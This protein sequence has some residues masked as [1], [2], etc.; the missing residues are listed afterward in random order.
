MP[1]DGAARPDPKPENETGLKL[2]AGVEC[3]PLNG[4]R[5]RIRN[6]EERAQRRA[7]CIRSAAGG[8]GQEGGRYLPGDGCLATG[9]LQLEE[10]LRRSGCK[11]VARTSAA[12][13]REPEAEDTGGGSDTGQAYSAGGAVK[14]SLTPAARRELVES[15][16][17]QYQMSEKR[18]CG[19]MGI[20][21][22]SN[23]YRS[24]KDPQMALRLRLREL[25]ASRVRYGYRRL[26][27]LLRREG[28][29]VNAKRVY[30]LYR[31]EGLQVRTAKRT[32]RAAGTGWHC[33]EQA[34]RTSDGVWISSVIGWWMA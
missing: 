17:Q 27:I 15:I 22:W 1:G 11:R 10:T 30:R 23:R 16:R 31:Q 32:R 4:S 7:D 12:A 33:P 34:G 14:K 21:R 20:T 8:S 19:L 24:C 5:R 18:A 29:K 13:G 3:G 6:A 28:W 25:G 26:T 2:R 9:V